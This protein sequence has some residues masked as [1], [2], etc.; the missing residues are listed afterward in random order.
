[1]LVLDEPTASLSV[2]RRAEVVRLLR[3]L[4]DEGRAILLVSHDLDEAFA[5]ADR[6]LVL[7]HGRLVASVSPA[8]VHTDDVTALM[9]GIETE[10]MTRRQLNRLKSLVEQLS[11]AAPAA[12]L[13]IVVS[14]TA[15]AL[16]QEMLC[17]HLLEPRTGGP[18][19]RRTAAVGLPPELL[20]ATSEL[21]VGPA[22]GPVGT[23]AQIGQLVVVDDVRDDPGWPGYL[24]VAASGGVRSTWSAPIVGGAGVL[25]AITGF[26]AA[27]GGLD[28]D[29]T[30]LVSL[31]AGHAATAIEREQLLDEVSRRN[32]ILESLRAMLE[33]LAGPDRIDGGLSAALLALCR[34]LNARSVGVLLREPGES[35]DG[36]ARFV[37]IDLDREDEPELRRIAESTQA[38]VDRPAR[39]AGGLAVAGLPVPDGSGVL[40]ARWHDRQE[41]TRERLELLDDARRSL[42]L[43]LEREGLERARREAAAARKSQALQRELLLQ[44]SHE[45]RTPLTAIRGYAS[46]LQQ[47]DLTWDA[48]STDRFLSAIATESARMERLVSDLLDSSAIES[49]LLRLRR[50][51]T[52]LRLVL[53]AARGCLPQ[54]N[55]IEL[56]VDSSLEPIWA[57]H[58]RLEQVFLNLFEN[59]VRHGSDAGTVAVVARPGP[60]GAAEVLVS[61]DGPGVPHEAAEQIF[62]PRVR[63]AGST[64]AGLGLAIARGVAEAHGG[65]CELLPGTVTTFRVV[66]PVEPMS[67][68]PDGAG[69]VDVQGWQSDG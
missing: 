51:W 28:P 16:D 15:A 49:G 25:G 42:G 63:G 23:A 2:M 64:G 58:D 59:A 27:A 47:P 52:D 32:A 21:P 54:R 20:E 37:V 5:L 36:A 65:G 40:V 61:D 38:S 10:S 26:S 48:E 14:A 41:P 3:E 68:V 60:D 67:A 17:V 31:Y 11:S 7:R 50:D 8:E 18:A 55:R 30:E 69:A 13:P 24:E 6:I 57:D 44:L 4:R 56:A 45:L 46:T 35:A 39:L 12:S 53:E 9:S 33:R 62:Q 34:G 66:L 22:G 29:R 43:A 19:L 1:M